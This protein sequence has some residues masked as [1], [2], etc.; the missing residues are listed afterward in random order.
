[1]T[2][3]GLPAFPNP[4]LNSQLGELR[5]RTPIGDV[6]K[7]SLRYGNNA[8]EKLTLPIPERKWVSVL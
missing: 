5:I 6:V 4:V 2:H 7:R 1:M 3:L 8:M